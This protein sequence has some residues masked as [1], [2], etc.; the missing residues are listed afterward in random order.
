MKG[1]FQMHGYKQLIKTATRITDQSKTL[2]DVIFSNKPE[3]IVKATVIP[4]ELSDHD[5]I[6]CSRK[7]NNT[8]YKPRSIKCRNY[9]NYNPELAMQ[10]LRNS[11]WK[12][13]YECDDVTTA[14]NF[15][16]DGLLKTINTHAPL[17]DKRVSGKPCEWLTCDVKAG[18][19]RRDQLLRKARK[20]NNSDDWNLYKNARN[21]ANNLL[22]S[23]KRKYYKSMLR[24]SSSKPNNFWNSI[25]KVFPTKGSKSSSSTFSIED[26][27][28]TDKSKIANGFVHYFTTIASRL[29]NKISPLITNIVWGNPTTDKYSMFSAFKFKTVTPSKVENILKKLSRRKATGND[30]IPCGFLKDMRTVIAKPL[31]RIINMSLRSGIIPNDL[32][33]AKIIPLH[34]SGTRSDFENY[35][36]I[37]IL[38]CISKVL[39]KCV[40][41]QVLLYLEDHSLLSS[42]QY[43]F[44]SSDQLN[45]Q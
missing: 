2:I 20:S 25:K 12:D 18:L 42:H 16:R 34:K 15:L 37:S 8:K 3:N 28:V 7:I 40:H 45:M 24:E 23:A 27:K 35:R 30:D 4:A 31:A 6:G 1:L 43:G 13:F 44:R 39:E 17:I 26:E 19:N 14:W 9:K 22:K 38:P 36:P 5:M 32:K 10:E 29:R 21:T 33:I 11:K 41:E